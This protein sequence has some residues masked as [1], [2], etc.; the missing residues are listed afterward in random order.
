MTEPRFIAYQG[1]AGANSHIAC[2]D[3]FPEMKPLPCATFEDAFA[4]LQDGSAELGMCKEPI[5]QLRV[6][7]TQLGVQFGDAEWPVRVTV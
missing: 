4:A 5:V 1:E 3:N 2:V 7:V 6:L